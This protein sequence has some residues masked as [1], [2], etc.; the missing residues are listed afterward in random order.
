[1]TSRGLETGDRLPT[2][3]TLFRLA[4][5]LGLEFAITPE[6]PLTVLP[7]KAA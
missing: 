6:E 7:H 1:M 2:V 3:D 5:I 4:G